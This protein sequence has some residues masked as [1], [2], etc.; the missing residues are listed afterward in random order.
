MTL[1]RLERYEE[2]R[3]RLSADSERYP[4]HPLFA[5]ALARLLSAAPDD[6]VRDARLAQQLIE[7]LLE[8]QQTIELGETTAMMLAEL[9]EYGQAAAVQRDVLAAAQ[10]AGL[11]GGVV[12]RL[13]VNLARYERGEPCRTPWTPEELP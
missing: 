7:R 2:A 8:Q 1:V 3:T 6:Q 13:E 9:G 5:H 10:Q 12:A 4:D 11:A